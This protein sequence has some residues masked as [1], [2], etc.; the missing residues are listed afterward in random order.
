M[1]VIYTGTEPLPHPPL[2]I[3]EWMAANTRTLA[4]PADGDYA[5][6]FELYN[7]N[8]VAVDLFGYRLTDDLT[9]TVKFVIP[10]GWSIPPGGHL[11]VW[12]DEESYRNLTGTNLHVNFKLSRDGERIALY[13]PDGSLADLV[14][15]GPQTER[16][17]PGPLARRQRGAFRFLCC[18]HSAIS[19]RERRLG[20]TAADRFAGRGT[21]EGVGPDLDRYSGKSV[22]SSKPQRACQTR[23]GR[24][25]PTP[26]GWETSEFPRQMPA[27]FSGLSNPSNRGILLSKL[28][29]NV[30][31]LLVAVALFLRLGVGDGGKP[32]RSGG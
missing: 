28:N 31:F 14:E 4:D 3:N 26:K 13:Y 5:D 27:P 20:P 21:A 2:F 22:T 1:T 7:P 32:E 19:Q 10:A 30:P 29:R 6:W 17:E 18:P 12:A 9:N 23:I 11:L 24:M 15:F 8:E 16:R 25:F